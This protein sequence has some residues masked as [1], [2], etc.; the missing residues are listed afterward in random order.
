MTATVSGRYR[1]GR[2]GRL[3]TIDLRCTDSSIAAVE[4]G[5]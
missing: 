3:L 4:G 5:R 2:G 1:P